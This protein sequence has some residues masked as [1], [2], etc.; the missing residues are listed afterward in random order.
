MRSFIAVL[1][2]VIFPLTLRGGPLLDAI[3][4]GPVT[5]AIVFSRENVDT[6]SVVTTKGDYVVIQLEQPLKPKIKPKKKL[7][8][9]SGRMRGP[10]VGCGSSSCGMCVINSLAKHGQSYDYIKTL[11]HTERMRLHYNLHHDK[12]FEGVKGKT[13]TVGGSR[14]RRVFGRRRR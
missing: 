2:L 13:Q 3:D 4:G 11:S 9:S 8:L 14:V 5:Q 1:V 10:D 12:D 6:F 7:D